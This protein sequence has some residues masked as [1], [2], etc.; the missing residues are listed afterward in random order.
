MLLILTQSPISM[1]FP[2]V[3]FP[4]GAKTVLSGVPCT[5]VFRSYINPFLCPIC[6]IFCSLFM[7]FWRPWVCSSLLHDQFEQAKLHVLHVKVRSLVKVACVELHI[8]PFIMV[9]F[10]ITIHFW[11]LSSDS[12]IKLFCFV[13]SSV[14]RVGRID[15]I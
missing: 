5:L 1:V 13:C 4:G 7:I 9:L 12:D 15:T 8:V 6:Y 10:Y 2:I 14:Y 11:N 3:R